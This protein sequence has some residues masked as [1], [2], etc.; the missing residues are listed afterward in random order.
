M[1]HRRVVIRLIITSEGHI[2]GQVLQG[3]T[4]TT[5]TFRRAIQLGEDLPDWLLF[6]IDI[7][8]VPNKEGKLHLFVATDQTSKFAFVQPHEQADGP[9]AVS[10]LQALLEAIL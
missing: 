9:T 7:A 4:H 3:S 5:E 2:V 8:E 10:F 6:H 1:L